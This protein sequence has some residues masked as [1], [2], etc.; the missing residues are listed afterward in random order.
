[1]EK[2]YKTKLL[3]VNLDDYVIKI[4]RQKA[5][6]MFR[7]NLDYYINWLICNNNKQ[8]TKK[9]VNAIEKEKEKRKPV[10]IPNTDKT[11]MYNNVCDYCKKS[12]YQGEEICKAEGYEKYIHKRC[13]R[14]LE[15]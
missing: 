9:I 3:S 4:A 2:L 8:E 5:R 14:N 7:G 12:I 11:A 15:T 1:M 10:P 6:V 13:C